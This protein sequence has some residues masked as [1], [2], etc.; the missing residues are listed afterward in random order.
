[1]FRL[2]LSTSKWELFALGGGSV[3][4]AIANGFLLEILKRDSRHVDLWTD[5]A[6]ELEVKN[7]I[8]GDIRVF[9]SPRY[10]RLRN[11]RQRLQFRLRMAM[12]ASIVVWVVVGIASVV[13]AT[14]IR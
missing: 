12:V 5:K 1:M 7:G 13:T 9:S 14:L 3:L 10:R 2:V 4:F 6:E 8:E 11:A